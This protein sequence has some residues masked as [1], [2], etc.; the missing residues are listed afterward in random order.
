MSE[1]TA[2]F[3]GR[4]ILSRHRDF[5]LYRP[6]AFVIARMITDVP[7][8]IAQATTFSIVFYFM[9]GFQTDAGKFFTFWIIS[10]IVALVLIQMY[11]FIGSAFSKFDNAA[12]VSG[13]WTVVLMVY[14]GYFIPYQSMHPWFQWLFWL[15]PA[16]YSYEAYVINE[17][18]GLTLKCV[19]NQLVP[20]GAGYDSIQNRACTVAGA[21][22]DGTSII[23]ADYI[24]YAFDY[25]VHHLWRN[26]GKYPLQ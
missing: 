24:Y 2:S 22:A 6:T 19:G 16:A 13:F 1:V 5:S 25:R 11:R 23:G 12:K 8:V 20:N 14:G 3:M 21:T 26:F 9:C 10:I 17:F 15:S 4:P 18:N 7:S